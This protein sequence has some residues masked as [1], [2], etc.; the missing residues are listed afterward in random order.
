[1]TQKFLFSFLFLFCFSF[2]IFTFAGKK[3]IKLRPSVSGGNTEQQYPRVPMRVPN[4]NLEDTTLSF[5]ASCI[6]CTI[7]LLQNH[8]AVFTAIIDEDGIV[9][10]PDYLFG[11]YEL[12]L[13]FG[14]LTFLGEIE[15]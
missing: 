13:Q 9:V 7:T 5:E 15:L 12:Q 4:V 1:M 6:G 3:T 10:L 2:S 14:S 8:N 11:V